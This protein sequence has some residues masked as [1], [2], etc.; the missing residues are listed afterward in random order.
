V[1]DVGPALRPVAEALLALPTGVAVDSVSVDP[2]ILPFETEEIALT[3][4]E[5][6]AT[7]N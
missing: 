2:S 3:L 6:D 4:P 1:K 7:A 5:E